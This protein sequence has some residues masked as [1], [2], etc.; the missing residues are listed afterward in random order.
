MKS[1][2]DILERIGV[3]YTDP[4]MCEAKGLRQTEEIE[5]TQT[6]FTIVTKDSDGMQCYEPDD[7][8]NVEIVTPSGD[9]LETIVKDTNDGNYKVTYT[10][11]CIGQH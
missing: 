8:I 1:K 4:K 11:E 7:Q 6:K 10:P 3:S 9:Q 2:P 5:K